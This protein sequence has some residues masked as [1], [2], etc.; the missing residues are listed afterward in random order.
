MGRPGRVAVVVVV[1]VVAVSGWLYA[2][3]P[4][5]LP[6]ALTE[7]FRGP[8]APS[9]PRVYDDGSYRFA[10][11]QPSG[12]GPVG[13]D[14][15]RPVDVQVNLDGAPEGALAMVRTTL[16]RIHRASGLDLRLD[17]TT[18]RRPGRV[19]GGRPVLVAWSTPTAVPELKGDVVGIGGS[20]APAQPRGDADATV[21][22][23][24]GQLVL[25][26]QDFADLGDTSRQAV[27]DHEMGHV[28]G[29]AHVD[30]RD[31]LM[32]P[33]AHGVTRFGHG[34]LT[35]LA[36]LGRVPCA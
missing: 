25:D 33:R 34:D 12:R 14:P 20:A 22:Y 8:E 28:V 3:A 27:L 32:Y 30:D 4:Q 31:E 21:H 23:V 24:T 6:T 2:F 18:D 15:C 5:S 35:G 11:T 17:G 19:L 36:L 7:P 10:R 13:Y 9:S 26:R 16:S 29:L 1:V